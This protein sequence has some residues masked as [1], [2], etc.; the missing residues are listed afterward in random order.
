MVK[1]CLDPLLPLPAF[2]AINLARLPPVDVDHVDVTALLAEMSALRREVR[3]VTQLKAEIEQ[4]KALLSPVFLQVGKTTAMPFH[5]SLTSQ[6]ASR[7][8]DWHKI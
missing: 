1:L 6:M 3:A 2:C 7:M 4:L 8:L 5:L